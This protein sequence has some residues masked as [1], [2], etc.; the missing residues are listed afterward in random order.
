MGVSPETAQQ[1]QQTA[2]E[3]VDYITV[4]TGNAPAVQWFLD[5]PY[6][7]RDG[8]NGRS[9]MDYTQIDA[10]LK[11]ERHPLAHRADL[12]QRLQAIESGY[13]VEL[14]KKVKK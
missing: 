5:H 4:H 9:G 2:V 3:T 13:M 14:S 7:W 11:L 8:I 1:Y 6:I 12:F 10:A